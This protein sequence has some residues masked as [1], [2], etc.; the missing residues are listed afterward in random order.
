MREFEFVLKNDKRKLYHRFAVLLFI[1][2][3]LG[4]WYFL[5]R[6]G[7][8]SLSDKTSGFIVLAAGILVLFSYFVN[9]DLRK[10]ESPF[11]L[12][13]LCLATYWILIGYWWIGLI[14]MSFYILY[15]ISIRELKIRVRTADIIYPSFP[16]KIIAWSSLSN[17]IFKD[18]LLTIDMKDN[19]IIQ[20]YVDESKTTVNET[21]FNE[22]CKIRLSATTNIS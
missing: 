19:R 2:N 12:G 16:K 1:L 11:L 3:G 20:Q 13:C 9:K 8:Q 6:S 17:I 4:I 15:I 5:T 10:K 7:R 18:G 22:F 21:E 14:V